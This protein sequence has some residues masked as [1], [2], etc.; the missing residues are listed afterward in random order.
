MK[1]KSKLHLKNTLVKSSSAL[2]EAVV[3]LSA[4]PD[5]FTT[6]FFSKPSSASEFKVE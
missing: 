2:P 1:L 3:P 6:F 4:P 5:L